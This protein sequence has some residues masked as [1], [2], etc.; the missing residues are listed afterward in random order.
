MITVL[1]ND[2][3]RIDSY[4]SDKLELSRSKVQ[5]LIKDN[6]VIV[7]GKNVKSNYQ[8]K[9]NDVI[10]VNDFLSSEMDDIYLL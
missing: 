4:L 7:N 1:D 3:L 2:G 6:C 9:L 5:R 8:V 10:E